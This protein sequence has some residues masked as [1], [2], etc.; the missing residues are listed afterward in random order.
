VLCYFKSNESYF[1]NVLSANQGPVLCSVDLLYIFLS[2]CFWNYSGDRGPHATRGRHVGQT[3]CN[4]CNWE[5]EWTAEGQTVKESKL[6]L[7]NLLGG[8]YG[9]TRNVFWFSLVK[10]LF[11]I[12]IFVFGNGQVGGRVAPAARN[13]GCPHTYLTTRRWAAFLLTYLFVV[14]F[15]G[16]TTHCGCIFTA[17]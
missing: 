2:N 10:Q 4:T 15:P 5:E 14:C 6:L 3:C 17:R 1:V 11:C 12:N 7:R 13:T 8:V 9:K 16:V